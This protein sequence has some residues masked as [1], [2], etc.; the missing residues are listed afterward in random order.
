MKKGLKGIACVILS[1]GQSRRMG[2]HKA[3]LKFNEN[4]R[5][6]DRII[7]VY[8]NFGITEV[9]VVA[10]ESLKNELN[11]ASDVKIVTNQHPEFER[12]Y[13]VKLAC[14]SLSREVELC[15]LQNCDNPFVNEELLENMINLPEESDCAVPVYMNQ[16]GHPVLINKT[17]IEYIQS[18]DGKNSNLKDI[19]SKFRTMKIITNDETVKININSPEEYEKY[20]I[21]K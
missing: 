7:E 9:I 18:I 13:S 20:F 14:E 4:L 19:L 11:V 2:T 3:L 5:F 10:G 17:I 6:I 1:A 15:F 21:N 16:G 12:F 8:K